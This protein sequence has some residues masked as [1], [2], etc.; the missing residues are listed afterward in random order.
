MI[1]QMAHI[2]VGDNRVF[3][4]DLAKL[5]LGDTKPLF[6]MVLL[7]D[8]PNI[9]VDPVMGILYRTASLASKQPNGS[10]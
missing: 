6:E 7:E 3:R 5:L 8:E 10:K 4:D 1:P 9:E 2:F